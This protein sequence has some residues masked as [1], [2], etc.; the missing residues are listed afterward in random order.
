[1]SMRYVISSGVLLALSMAVPAAAEVASWAERL[2]FSGDFRL[3]YE[4][5]DAD[6][7]SEQSRGRYRL[8]L[9]AGIELYDDLRFVM[10]LATAADNPVSRNVTFGGNPTSDSFGVDL[11][12]VEWRPRPG[13]EVLAGKMK[14]PMFL[15]GKDQLIYDNDLNPG[16]VAVR[17]APG[18]TF[19]AAGAFL[20]RERA[21]SD[22]TFV[23]HG[24]AGIEWGLGEITFTTGAGYVAVTNTVG[25]TP[26]FFDLPAGNTVDAMNRYVF[27]YENAE[28]FAELDAALY[29]RPLRLFAHYTENLEVSRNDS[30]V[31]VGLLLGK[32]EAAGSWELGWT[33]KDLE[34]DAVVGSFTESDFGGGGTGTDGH[35]LRGDYVLRERLQL[36]ATVFLNEDS[37]RDDLENYRRVQLDLE[38]EF[39]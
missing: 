21:Q 10:S 17:F 6:G 39:E 31:A 26:F 19:L 30:A 3:R 23:Y 9:N 4:S 35:V 29:G 16:G 12:Y 2:E 27:E 13:L 15:P 34:A 8:R 28:V 38:F 20:V 18:R 32:A 7:L 11:A 22:D 14:N 33:F 37:F 5:I 36:G 24:Q 25:N 1:M